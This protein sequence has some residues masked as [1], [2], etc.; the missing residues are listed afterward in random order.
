ME[1][2]ISEIVDRLSILNLKKDRGGCDC[3][4]EES[5]FN[6]ALQEYLDKGID[7]KQEW[8]NEL[9]MING[10]IWDLECEIRQG[11]EEKFTLEEVGRRALLIRD[12]N[13]KRIELKNLI[14]QETGVGFVGKKFQH[15]SE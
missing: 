6:K 11:K 10:K 14:V 4:E 9:L 7:Y 3:L 2:P 12:F 1:Y 5:A 8:L 15:A 13:K